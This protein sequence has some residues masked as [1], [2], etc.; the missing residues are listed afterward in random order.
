MLSLA[1]A[2]A[3]AALPA[4]NRADRTPLGGAMPRAPLTVLTNEPGAAV[5]VIYSRWGAENVAECVTPCTV[6]VPT[7]AGVRVRVE[8]DGRGPVSAPVLRWRAGLRADRL[9]PDTLNLTLAGSRP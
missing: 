4:P 2:A 5:R 7:L 8:K 3:L 6:T 9:E 1:L